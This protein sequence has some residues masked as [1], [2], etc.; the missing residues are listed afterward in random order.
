[1]LYHKGSR[2]EAVEC[3]RIASAL[4]SA[5][6]K[7]ANLCAWVF[8][9]SERHDKAG[10]AYESLLALRPEWADGHRPERVYVELVFVHALGMPEDGCSTVTTAGVVEGP[11][12]VEGLNRSR[13]NL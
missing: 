1:V 2:D 3:P 4:Q 6:E 9:D 13:G 11:Q 8:S 5:D 12:R 10:A 7:I